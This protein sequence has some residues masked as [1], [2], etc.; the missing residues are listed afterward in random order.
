MPISVP[1][2][3]GLPAQRRLYPFSVIPGGAQ[4]AQELAAAAR[5]DSVVA[6]HY[7]DFNIA[8][9]R[10]MTLDRDLAVYVSYRMGRE[11]F[12]TNKKIQ[13]H[14]GEQLLTDGS[15]EARTRCGNRISE[16]R[17]SPLAPANSQPELEA[18]DHFPPEAPLVAQNLPFD[19]SLVPPTGFGFPA[20][21]ARPAAMYP[22]PFLP[23]IAGPRS[24]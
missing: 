18:F 23:F 6:A 2:A 10:V 15:H 12:W 7:A 21:E 1:L 11:V 14:K 3:D 20:P 24:P 4:N 8:Q 19:G 22:A 13:L 5:N 16:E 9:T 17:Q